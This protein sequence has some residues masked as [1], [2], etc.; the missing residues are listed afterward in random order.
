MKKQLIIPDAMRRAY[1]VMH[2]APGVKVGDT[3]YVSGQ[4]GITADGKVAETLEEQL[5]LC[6]QKIQLVLEAAGGTLD[7]I[8]ELESFHVGDM[9]ADTATI[10]RVKDVYLTHDYP[11]WS[12]FAVAGL[13]LPGLLVE[14]KAIAVIGSGN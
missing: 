13:A 8:V 1:D 6:F 14:I 11:A 3:V 2:F 9:V 7:D 10:F 5:H 12:S 4:A